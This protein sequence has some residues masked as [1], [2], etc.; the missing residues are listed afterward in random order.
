MIKE[1]LEFLGAELGHSSPSE[2]SSSLIDEKGGL[3]EGFQTT[4]KPLLDKAK[5]DKFNDGKREGK[6]EGKGWA[7]K[8]MKSA[9]EKE[10]SEL[11]GV[12]AAPIKDMAKTYAEKFKDSQKT[13]K[14]TEND[15]LNSQVHL[16]IV[17]KYKTDLQAAQEELGKLTKAQ[18]LSEKVSKLRGIAKPVFEEKY[19]GTEAAFDKYLEEYANKYHVE[20]EG[21]LAYP[22]DDNKSRIRSKE[23][24]E[25]QSFIDHFRKTQLDPYFVP[26]EKKASTPGDKGGGGS[27]GNQNQSFPYT[28]VKEWSE[29]IRAAKPED[30]AAL[31]EASRKW[32]TSQ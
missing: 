19:I 18:E 11:L 29:A 20:F 31:V 5:T 21:D 8:E 14:I 7:E 15:I 27:N 1:L 4:F 24:S 3:K 26:R 22:V 16:D 32:E 28:S 6:N 23:N 17:K 10:I 13:A 25:P 30:K 12:E 9:W 2:L